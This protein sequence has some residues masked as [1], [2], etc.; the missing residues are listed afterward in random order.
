M[1]DHR[2]TA[3]QSL[4]VHARSRRRTFFSGYGSKILLSSKDSGGQ[5]SLI[6]GL[7]SAGRRWRPALTYQRGRIDAPSG[8]RAGG[9]YRREK[10]SY[11]LQAKAISLRAGYPASPPKPEPNTRAFACAND[12]GR[13]RRNSFPRPGILLMGGLTTTGRTPHARSNGKTAQSS[14]SKP[15][16][17]DYCSLFRATA[18]VKPDSTIATDSSCA[19][20]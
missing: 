20:I 6:E 19:L 1:K 10:L 7:M 5:F 3:Q 17:Q 8:R 2:T 13:F 11:R 14:P 18:G 4:P 12:T 9:H 15:R 16:H